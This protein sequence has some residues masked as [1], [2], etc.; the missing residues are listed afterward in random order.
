MDG[1]VVTYAPIEEWQ[2]T[3][4]IDGSFDAI[5]AAR[6]ACQEEVQNLVDTRLS[7]NA[8]IKKRRRQLAQL[9]RMARIVEEPSP[10]E[11]AA[12]LLDEGE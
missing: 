4:I 12:T 2:P 3:E 11:E 8:D 9:E 6:D 7:I 5:L 1:T 10:E